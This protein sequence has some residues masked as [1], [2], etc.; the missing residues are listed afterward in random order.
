MPSKGTEENEEN[1][2]TESKPTVLKTSPSVDDISS[3]TTSSLKDSDSESGEDFQ[4]MA[5][6]SDE[7][8][9]HKDEEDEEE[10]EVIIWIT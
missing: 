8:V 5:S 7:E 4:I 1:E 9:D 3:Q 10:E 6:D 2:T